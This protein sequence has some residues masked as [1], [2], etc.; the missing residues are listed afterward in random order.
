MIMGKN[1]K[2]L[3]SNTNKTVSMQTMSWKVQAYKAFDNDNILMILLHQLLNLLRLK[4]KL[5]HL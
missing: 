3:S 2:L 5:I 1:V 4:G